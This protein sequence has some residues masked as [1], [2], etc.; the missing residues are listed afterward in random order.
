MKF[1]VKIFILF[2]VLLATEATK[3]NSTKL[4][5]TPWKKSY[6]KTRQCIKKQR[7]HFVDK[8][9]SSQ[10][11]GF[12]SSHIYRC[13]SWTIRE[14]WVLKNWCFQTVVLEKTPESLLD[15]NQS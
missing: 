10:S 5:D 14:G 11:Y 2:K 1:T 7:H 15:S 12:S 13:E 3:H 4:K 6:D 8:G 9:L